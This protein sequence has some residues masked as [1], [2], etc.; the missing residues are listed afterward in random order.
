MRQRAENEPGNQEGAKLQVTSKL[1]VS[2][3]KIAPCRAVIF[4][5]LKGYKF[6]FRDSRHERSWRDPLRESL[7][8]AYKLVWNRHLLQKSK[9]NYLWEEIKKSM[10][11]KSH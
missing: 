5:I 3:V 9:K 11:N 1:Q 8:V 2:S 7:K 6:K 10:Q 4:N